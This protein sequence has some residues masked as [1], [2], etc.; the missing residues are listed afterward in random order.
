MKRAISRAKRAVAIVLVVLTACHRGPVKVNVNTVASHADDILKKPEVE[1]E[2]VESTTEHSW[3]K[4]T[5]TI[6]R[7]QKLDLHF[8]QTT[9]GELLANCPETPIPMDD[10][11]IRAAFPNCKL[12]EAA[13]MSQTIPVGTR[14]FVHRAL[15]GV[16]GA[17]L[18]LGIVY[19]AWKCESPYQEVAIGTMIVGGVIAV[20][21]IALIAGI[22]K[23]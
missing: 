4:T 10:R 20:A 6:R 8:G 2:A 1:V 12:F 3:R 16:A 14:L 5:A 22:S 9:F 11:D 23:D 19:C 18:G 17:A 7:D 21:A 13:R 15:G